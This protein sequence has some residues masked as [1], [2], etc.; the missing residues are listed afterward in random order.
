[1]KF[2]WRRYLWLGGSL[3]VLIAVVFLTERLTRKPVTPEPSRAEV[4]QAGQSYLQVQVIDKPACPE[5]WSCTAVAV[6]TLPD[7]Q[8]HPDQN[9][10]DFLSRYSCT[11]DSVCCRELKPVCTPNWQCVQPLNC[12]ETDLNQCGEPDRNAKRCCPAE[13]CVPNWACREPRDCYQIDVNNCPGSVPQRFAPCCPTQN[14]T[15]PTGW[16]C[17][18]SLLCWGPD[19]EVYPDQNSNEFL[20][21]Y[22]CTGGNVCC[23]E[24]Q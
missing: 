11:G 2:P 15:C 20:S 16:S 14:Y 17:W 13:T 18:P 19:L 24:V 3:A 8:I 22:T 5:D 4:C 23:R 10:G 21:R 1:M 9:S 6:C 12:R 7:H